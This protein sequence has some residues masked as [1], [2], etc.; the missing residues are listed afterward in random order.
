MS[1]I[2][3][4]TSRLVYLQLG[5]DGIATSALSYE[6]CFLIMDNSLSRRKKYKKQNNPI[7]E[8]ENSSQ[9]IN[10]NTNERSLIFDG[11]DIVHLTRLEFKIVTLLFQNIGELVTYK[12]L[13]QSIIKEN[14]LD[15]SHFYRV[16]NLV[17][18]IRKKIS[19]KVKED[20]I[21]TIRSK[22]YILDI[23]KKKY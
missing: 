6:E 16:T 17:C 1:S 7:S 9:E 3:N 12:E 10:L 21:K 8:E 18:H 5:V 19:T 20:P 2:D 23:K 15:D 14:E 4:K 13:H 11:K 22:G